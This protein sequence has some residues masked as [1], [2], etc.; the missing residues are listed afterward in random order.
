MKTG[1]RKGYTNRRTLCY[2]V[3]LRAGKLTPIQATYAWQMLARQLEERLAEMDVPK[4]AAV[5]GL[6]RAATIR[7]KSHIRNP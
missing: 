6:I 5:L 1:L 3:G 7:A 4:F 2:F